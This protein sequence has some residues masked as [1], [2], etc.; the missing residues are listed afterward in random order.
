M[1]RQGKLPM[2]IDGCYVCS[3]P[4]KLKEAALE[5]LKRFNREFNTEHMKVHTLKI[6]IDGTLK[7][8]TAAMVGHRYDRLHRLQRRR[9]SGGY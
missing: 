6:F 7:I 2:Y 8:H 5:E 9:T 4:N 3:R 1:D